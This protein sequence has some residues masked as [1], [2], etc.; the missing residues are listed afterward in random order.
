MSAHFQSSGPRSNAYSVSKFTNWTQ[1]DPFFAEVR[2]VFKR[3]DGRISVLP[4]FPHVVV[5]KPQTPDF[6]HACTRAEV[7]ARLE[8]MPEASR[9][10]LRAVFL[11]AGTRK[12]E[13]SWWSKLGCYGSYWNSCVFL[14]AHPFKLHY[15]HCLDRLRSF[16][17]DDVLVHE[18]AH[19]IDRERIADKKAK[20]AFAHAY[21]QKQ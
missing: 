8:R 9:R 16:F 2:A 10:G 15:F 12:Q 6:I 19:H 7:R 5:L 14:Y 3:F 13:K 11:L 1:Y 17:L 4:K 20:E 21:V 18:V